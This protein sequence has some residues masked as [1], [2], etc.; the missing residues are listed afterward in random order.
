MNITSLGQFL[1]TSFLVGTVSFDKPRYAVSEDTGQFQPV[2]TRT[3]MYTA[4][5]YI[6]IG[7]HNL[8]P[9]SKQF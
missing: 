7:E 3:G 1:F 8:T 2:L 6:M 4:N 5:F 9:Q